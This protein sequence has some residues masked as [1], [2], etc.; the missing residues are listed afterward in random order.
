M[1]VLIFET[2]FIMHCYI[3]QGRYIRRT[4]FSDVSIV[5]FLTSI[6][7]SLFIETG[8]VTLFTG[9][10]IITLHEKVMLYVSNHDFRF[11]AYRNIT[12]ICRSIHF[13]LVT[14]VY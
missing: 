9:Y 13:G 4:A 5:K 3:K 6:Y 7:S 14:V 1:M 2:N 8:L 10:K 12:K 11:F